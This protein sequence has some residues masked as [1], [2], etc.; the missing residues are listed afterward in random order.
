M[1]IAELDLNA[2]GEFAGEICFDIDILFE[3]GSGD[4][5]NIYKKNNKWNLTTLQDSF[6]TPKTPEEKQEILRQILEHP[7]VRLQFLVEGKK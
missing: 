1:K 4:F 3:N 2:I 6:G 5:V 7:K